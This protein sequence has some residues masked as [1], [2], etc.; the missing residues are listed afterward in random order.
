[1]MDK[2]LFVEYVFLV[3]E[4]GKSCI[5]HHKWSGQPWDR[6]QASVLGGLSYCIPLNCDYTKMLDFSFVWNTLLNRLSSKCTVSLQLLVS[7]NLQW[8][9]GNYALPLQWRCIKI[10]IVLCLV[11]LL[12]GETGKEP[13]RVIV[14]SAE[15]ETRICKYE[16]SASLW[17][18][19][20]I[21]LWHMSGNVNICCDRA[22]WR[23]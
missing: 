11:Q 23:H 15:C 7:V 14:H 19:K 1:L 2:K 10:C 21:K 3:P 5:V 4:R 13:A 17:T 12:M 22:C 9:S 18:F 8:H 16:W 20:T 6:T